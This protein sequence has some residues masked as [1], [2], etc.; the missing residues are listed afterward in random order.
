MDKNKVVYDFLFIHN[1]PRYARELESEGSKF[2]EVPSIKHVFRYMGRIRDVVK[3]GNYDAVYFNL[4]FSHII[5]IIAA[6]CGGAKRII[7]HSH[8][9]YID[10]NKLTSRLIVKAYHSIWL[11]FQEFFI[12]YHFACSRIAGDFLF[13][14]CPKSEVK[15]IHN[16]I[17]IEKFTFNMESRSTV[18]KELGVDV[19]THII[20]HVGRFSYQKNHEFLLAVFREISRLDKN[21]ILVL[22]G[23]GP[24]ENKIRDLVSKYGIVGKVRFLGRQND[25][26]RYLQAMDC[27]LFPSRFEGL[28]IVL[29]EAQTSGLPCVVADTVP[30]ESKLGDNIY[31]LSLNDSPVIWAQKVLRCIKNGRKN[32]LRSIRSAGYDN[33]KEAKK[34]ESFYFSL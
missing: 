4:S 1:K 13:P 25:V 20:G 28:G 23:E 32:N 16:A 11:L 26:N 19:N 24:E 6:K 21:S 12:D 27:F 34:L 22:I 8:S 2:Y 10:R 29:V 14:F 7:V 5:P 9:S 15:I 31:F 3:N 18:R 17:D 33:K 30:K